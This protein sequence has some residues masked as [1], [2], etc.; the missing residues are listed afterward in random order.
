MHKLT[1]SDR[2]EEFTIIIIAVSNSRGD[3]NDIT[4][5]HLR[6]EDEDNFN[7]NDGL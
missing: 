2:N 3:D 4:W 7:D 5:W 1:Q 6:A